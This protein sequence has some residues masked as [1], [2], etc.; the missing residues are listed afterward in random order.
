[1]KT[2]TNYRIF[3]RNLQSFSY[4][5][6]NNL[7]SR[8]NAHY[9][10]PTINSKT[11]S[12]LSSFDLS[13][14]FKIYKESPTLV[15]PFHNPSKISLKLIPRKLNFNIPLPYRNNNLYRNSITNPQNIK[16]RKTI[17]SKLNRPVIN[18]KLARIIKD[19]LKHL[20]ILDFGSNLKI[21]D[22]KEKRF[23]KK[24]I[25]DK[26]DKQLDEIYYDYDKSNKKVI[27]N[28]FSGNNAD[29]LRN[30]VSFVTGIMNYLY[31]KIVLNKMEFLKKMK[32]K[33]LREEKIQLDYDLK[34]V[35]YNLKHKNPKENA[36]ISKYFYL[37]DFDNLKYGKYLNRPKTIVNNNV[38]SKLKYEY[39]FM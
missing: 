32:H 2:I 4:Q 6:N 17:K 24:V 37:D 7:K 12:S 36:A 34:G 11:I 8:N 23:K 5:K 30:K 10:I 29:L 3:Q 19:K 20:N 28:S 21:Y 9:T 18:M 22:E 33:E 15:F 31:P 26:F 38:I 16:K 14:K 35:Y 39:D 27:I 13:S 25:L 1:M